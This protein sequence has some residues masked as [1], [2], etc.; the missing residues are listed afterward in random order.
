M[1]RV[2][3]SG[4]V[5][6]AVLQ[7]ACTSAESRRE[8][9]EAFDREPA[10]QEAFS[11]TPG[12]DCRYTQAE[13][14]AWRDGFRDAVNHVEGITLATSSFAPIKSCFFIGVAADSVRP[15]VER[16]LARNRVPLDAVDIFVGTVIFD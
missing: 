10:L 16:E 2:F 3:I 1:Q 7:L 13:L 14:M 15:I 4:A 9:P 12:F 8:E 5:I 6:L 11:F